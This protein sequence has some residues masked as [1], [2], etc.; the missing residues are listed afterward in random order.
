MRQMQHLPNA[1]D[2]TRL[3]DVI[4]RQPLFSP[5]LL[6]ARPRY[7]TH[8]PAAAYFSFARVT[9]APRISG[10]LG[11]EGNTSSTPHFALHPALRDGPR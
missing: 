11:C 2:P 10:S 8:A 9:P 3:F 6:L 5:A 4:D 1:I 7:P